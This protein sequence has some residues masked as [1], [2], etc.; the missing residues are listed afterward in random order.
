MKLLLGW[1]CSVWESTKKSSSAMTSEAL[2]FYTW[3]GEILRY[4]LCATFLLLTIFFDK[5]RTNFSSFPALVIACSL[6]YTVQICNKLICAVLGP[7]F[8]KCWLELTTE[9]ICVIQKNFFFF[10]PPT[11]WRMIVLQFRSEGIGEAHLISCWY[12]CNIMFS[13]RAHCFH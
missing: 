1:I 11:L 12:L 6:A 8:L 9:N 2:S 10:F 3:K 4:F 13:S 5:T 7:D